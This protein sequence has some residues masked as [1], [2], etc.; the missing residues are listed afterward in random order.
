MLGFGVQIFEALVSMVGGSNL[1]ECDAC[2]KFL[3]LIDLTL[4]CRTQ[5]SIVGF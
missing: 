5:A 2:N 3:E 4:V 1:G